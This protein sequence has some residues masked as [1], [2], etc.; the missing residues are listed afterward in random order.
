[1]RAFISQQTGVFG[2][3]PLL[4]V[5]PVPFPIVFHLRVLEQRHLDDG[6]VGEFADAEADEPQGRNPVPDF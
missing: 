4:V 6:L 1:M 2:E 5:L 3:R